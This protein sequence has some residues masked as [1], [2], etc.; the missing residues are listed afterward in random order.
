MIKVIRLT[1]A[2]FI[3]MF[4][5]SC[6]SN[7]NH[8]PAR[9]GQVIDENSELPIEGA[10]V[11]AFWKGIASYAT[12][13]CFHIES[14]VSDKE[15]NFTIPAWT[16]TGEWTA[17]KDQHVSFTIH[18][19][20]YVESDKTYGQEQTQKSKYFYLSPTSSADRIS[21]IN[22]LVQYKTCPE[23][24]DSGQNLVPFL[25]SAMSDASDAA[26]TDKDRLV[27]ITLQR[28]IDSI[29][30]GDDAAWEIWRNKKKELDIR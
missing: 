17:L 8:W 19:K 28:M 13:A 10:H 1:G 18:K 11:V 5:S 25:K 15:G 26:K 7:T 9:H 2:I 30:V 6:V 3:L 20:G 24:G 16:N 23:S 22:D 27:V 4:T 12:E 21:Y 14:A 29:E